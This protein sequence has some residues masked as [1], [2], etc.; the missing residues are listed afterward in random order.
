MIYLASDHAG[1]Q[2]KEAIK[3]HLSERSF[4]VED[5]GAFTY[6]ENDDYPDF[7]IPAAQKVGENPE[8]NKA[9]ILGGSGQGEAIAA[10]KVRGV[11]AAVY[12]GGP[13]D[14]VKLSRSHNN[15]NMLSLGAKFL[16][17]EEAKEVVKLW[18]ETGFDGGRHERRIEKIKT[19]E[20]GS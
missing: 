15:A 20:Q 11:R 5:C 4:V 2:L 14:L 17:L 18:L 7:I 19:F 10:N 9:I 16:T 12:Y 8:G 6:D 3:K 1:Y 13:L